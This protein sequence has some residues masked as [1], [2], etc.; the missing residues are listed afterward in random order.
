MEV[1]VNRHQGGEPRD[2]MVSRVFN[3]FR[4]NVHKTVGKKTMLTLE[5][6]LKRIKT[7]FAV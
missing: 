6:G 4:Q 3:K 1:V 7:K 5:S 2:L